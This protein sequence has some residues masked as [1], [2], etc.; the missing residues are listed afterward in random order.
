[1]AQDFP[2]GLRSILAEVGQ[3]AIEVDCGVE[4]FREF[5]TVFRCDTARMANFGNRFPY[6][7]SH[8]VVF[9]VMR[10]R[11]E[12]TLI[13]NH[14]D[15]SMEALV[16]LQSLYVPSEE[17]RWAFSMSGGYPQRRSFPPLKR[18]SLFSQASE[19]KRPWR[20]SVEEWPVSSD[21]RRT[22]SGRR[23]SCC[24]D[25]C[26]TCRHNARIP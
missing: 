24:F 12:A 4:G 9:R 1:M 22:V 21:C 14:I 19:R 13:G 5:V 20:E 6:L 8:P 18:Q 2:A 17:W 10:F 16:G 3:A 25:A 23:G 26:C 15:V 11:V 7:R